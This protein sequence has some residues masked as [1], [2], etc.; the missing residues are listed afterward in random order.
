MQRRDR[1]RAPTQNSKRRQA[2]TPAAPFETTNRNNRDNNATP[3]PGQALGVAVVDF[4]DRQLRRDLARLHAYGWRAEYAML[5]ELGA[6]F[7]IRTEIEAL[8]RR[9]AENLD[10]AMLAALGADELSS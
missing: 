2:G 9:Y 8:V 4:R 3:P 5:S 6:R 7:M 10:P 1:G